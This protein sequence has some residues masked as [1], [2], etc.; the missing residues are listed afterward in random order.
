MKKFLILIF[1][2]FD[3]SLLLCSYPSEFSFVGYPQESSVL[4]L[5]PASLG[6]LESFN[7]DLS[8]GLLFKSAI[9][10]NFYNA[11][12]SF[13]YGFKKFF[14]GFG[15]REL[16]LVDI[17]SENLIL[18]NFGTKF[19]NDK[20]FVGLNFKCYIFKYFYDE[21][22]KE[23]ILATND[24]KS[25]NLDFGM[26]TKIKDNIFLSFSI[27][28]LIESSLGEQIK[29]S[30][31]TDYI[32]AFGYNYNYSTINFEYKFTKTTIDRNVFN[33][34]KFKLG[35]KQELFYTKNLSFNI[36]TA[37]ERLE[38]FNNFVLGGEL[39]FLNNSLGLRYYWSY[40][41]SFSNLNS[42]YG[43]HYLSFN[44]SFGKK[45]RKIVIHQPEVKEEV[46]V[47]EKPKEELPKVSLKKIEVSSPS[48]GIPIVEGK[49]L[50]VEEEIKISTYPAKPLEK[51]VYQPKEKPIEKEVKKIKK[52]EYEEYK[53]YNFPI[54]HKVLEG[55]TLISISKK[56]YNNEKEWKKIYEANKDKIIKGVPIVGEILIIPQP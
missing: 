32:F 23:D 48:V 54:A 16:T 26:M 27:L 11:E 42:F 52:E 25:Y 8:Y 5:N 6:N 22:Y 30:L 19:F 2:I 55:E 24:I 39:R 12:L 40:P 28:N 38:E 46:V 37:L 18:G 53:K 29:Y 31:P 21:Y 45:K 4:F 10:E 7:L 9:K 17:Y 43:N 20:F 35:I 15:Y 41:M 56:Y 33:N 3:F 13:S 34:A 36:I 51:V 47:I 14:L 44:I 49:T 1:L 50:K